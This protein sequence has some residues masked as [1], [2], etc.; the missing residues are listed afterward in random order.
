MRKNR[1]NKLELK[2]RLW[3]ADQYL[4]CCGETL[5]VPSEGDVAKIAKCYFEKME[6]HALRH[7]CDAK[8]RAIYKK[9]WGEGWGIVSSR[10]KY[11][12]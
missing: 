2:L 1:E 3:I 5:K 6:K 11:E 10:I 12:K 8:I 4:K 7:Q 9:A